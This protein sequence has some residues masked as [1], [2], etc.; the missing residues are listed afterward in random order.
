[1]V[2]R[3]DYSEAFKE[4]VFEYMAQ[5]HSMRKTADRFNISISTIR[6][7]RRVRN[8]QE[9]ERFGIKNKKLNSKDLIEYIDEHPFA[10]IAEMAEKFKCSSSTVSLVL[11][12]NGFSKGKSGARTGA[13]WH[14]K[15]K[16]IEIKNYS[17]EF[18]KKVCEYIQKGVSP[19]VIYETINI[20]KPILI[21]WMKE[22]S[23]NGLI[24]GGTF[25][26]SNRAVEY[27]KEN[28]NMTIPEMVEELGLPYNT[29]YNAL[30]RSGYRIEGNSIK[31]KL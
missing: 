25:S 31:L 4:E 5:G 24:K 11:S 17:E 22:L 28:P 2:Y 30:R 21:K 3:F 18:K 12:E 27:F 20:S 13:P 8:V 26:G 16:L 23:E 10:T 7:W 15:E 19:E 14:R 1:M 9:V 29:I 6:R